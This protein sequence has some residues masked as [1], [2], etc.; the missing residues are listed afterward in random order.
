M[1][2]NLQYTFPV[3][4]VQPHGWRKKGERLEVSDNTF[5]MW[6]DLIHA[7]WQVFYLLSWSEHC[8]YLDVSVKLGRNPFM[9]C[10]EDRGGCLPNHPNSTLHITKSLPWSPLQNQTNSH[11]SKRIMSTLDTRKSL[12]KGTER[13]TLMQK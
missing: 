11:G 7:D 4:S 10:S 2:N 1:G 9:L 12:S 5:E 8:A 3:Y 13:H 6:R